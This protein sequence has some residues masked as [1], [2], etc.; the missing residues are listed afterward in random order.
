MSKKASSEF[1]RKKEGS[2]N[3][4]RFK[5]ALNDIKNNLPEIYTEI[6][7]TLMKNVSITDRFD[8]DYSDLGKNDKGFYL[9]ITVCP[10]EGDKDNTENSHLDTDDHEKVKE[11]ISRNLKKYDCEL[12]DISFEDI[13]GDGHYNYNNT[14]VRFFVAPIEIE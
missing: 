2:V 3:Y 11:I 6:E 4:Y 7:S 13:R 8:G 9:V 1:S 14:I 12:Y 5:K 10:N